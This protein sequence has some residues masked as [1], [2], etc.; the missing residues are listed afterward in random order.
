MKLY[1]SGEHT[2]TGLARILGVTCPTIGNW[3]RHEGLPPRKRGRPRMIEPS[4]SQRR[5]IELSLLHSHV[6]VA[7]RL[8]VSRQYVDQVLEKWSGFLP[9][10]RPTQKPMPAALQNQSNRKIKS[11]AIAFRVTWPDSEEL[12]R[13]AMV[14]PE[15]L[16]TQ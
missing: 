3:A 1:C 6:E 15:S 11:H 2:N 5:I 9:V 13:Q 10:S 14:C 7:A 12:R 4:H 16:V 8:G